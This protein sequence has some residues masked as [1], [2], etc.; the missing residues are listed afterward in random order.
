MG[1]TALI[2]GLFLR[3]LIPDLKD[4]SFVIQLKKTEDQLAEKMERI[5]KLYCQGKSVET[6][7]RIFAA[8]CEPIAIFQEKCKINKNKIHFIYD[9]SPQSAIMNLGH[10]NQE[11]FIGK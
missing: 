4:I 5:Y 1:I 6:K 3:C 11:A 7:I 9:G 8:V 10:K 2:D